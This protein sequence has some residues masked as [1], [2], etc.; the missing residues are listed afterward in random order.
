MC[1]PTQ[2]SRCP[3]S[4]GGNKTKAL[5]MCRHLSRAGWRVVL[6]DGDKYVSQKRPP[7]V[8]DVCTSM[9][10]A[11]VWR[12]LQLKAVTG[13]QELVLQFALVQLCISVSLSPGA[14]QGPGGLSEGMSLITQPAHSHQ[15]NRSL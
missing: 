4:A 1:M 7:A 3:V 12:P 8:V 11:Q 9:A 10:V 6:V 15:L 13:A 2:S 14:K 5:H